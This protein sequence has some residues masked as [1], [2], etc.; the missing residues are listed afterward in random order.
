L[1]RLN[2]IVHASPARDSK[3]WLW[4]LH[5]ALAVALVYPLIVAHLMVETRQQ[6]QGATRLPPATRMPP[7]PGADHRDPCRRLALAVEESG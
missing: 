1:Y 3:D 4:I 5:P 7:A 6:R 2:L